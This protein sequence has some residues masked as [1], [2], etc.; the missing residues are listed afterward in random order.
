M[1]YEDKHFP[2]KRPYLTIYN[3]HFSQVHFFDIQKKS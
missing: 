1:K 2:K 3:G